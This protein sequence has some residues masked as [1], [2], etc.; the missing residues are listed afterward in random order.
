[1]AL[2]TIEIFIERS[3]A[4][5]NLPNLT[6]LKTLSFTYDASSEE[7]GKMLQQMT[8]LHELFLKPR[9]S[10]AL[11]L[12]PILVNHTRL[13]SFTYSPVE[14]VTSVMG[15][16]VLKRLKYLSI[17]FSTEV[18]DE[19]LLPIMDMTSLTSLEL[20]WLNAMT[21]KTIQ[22][23]TRLV[24]LEH[25]ELVKSSSLNDEDY[26]VLQLLTKITFLDLS[27]NHIHQPRMLESI[28]T[29]TQLTTLLM[30]EETDAI[31]DSTRDFRALTILT[32]LMTLSFITHQATN[33][34]LTPFMNLNE[35]SINT[36][37]LLFDL[38]ALPHLRKVRV[39]STSFSAKDVAEGLCK[40]TQ[41]TELNLANSKL[42]DTEAF[43]Q[44][45]AN[46]KNLMHLLF[47]P[48]SVYAKKENVVDKFCEALSS[49]PSL[50]TLNLREIPA[51]TVPIL[52]KLTRLGLLRTVQPYTPGP[53]DSA[54]PCR[55]EQ[56]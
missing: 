8:Y 6:N 12:A 28:A 13:T 45:C 22:H 46:L 33:L 10:E 16:N 42:F 25:L 17:Q 24:N 5:S 48:N 3:L 36:N 4:N 50:A 29:L 52:R 18:T 26:T 23:L 9:G 1:M 56:L 20:T 27:Y 47:L 15:L 43:A 39:E 41:I 37:T 30:L 32:N 38:A 21:N 11:D 53:A 7:E 35:I 49:L 14:T 19:H 44:H 51:T 40:L 2:E 55:V 34:T 31:N 54:L